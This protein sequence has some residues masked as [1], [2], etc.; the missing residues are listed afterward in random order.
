MLYIFAKCSILDVC[1]GSEYTYAHPFS[2]KLQNVELQI[3]QLC[4]N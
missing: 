1:Q 4:S 3:F 2:E